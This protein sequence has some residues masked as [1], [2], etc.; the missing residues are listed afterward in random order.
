[1]KGL[2]ARNNND[3]S[4]I[5]ALIVSCKAPLAAGGTTSATAVTAKVTLKSGEVVNGYPF[6]IDDWQITIRLPS[7]QLRTFLRDEVWPKY[8]TVNP[9]QAHVD[10]VFKYKDADIHNLAAYLLTLK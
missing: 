8:D 6:S 10:L 2:A 3:A 1:M 7:G 9:L 4:T 5:Q